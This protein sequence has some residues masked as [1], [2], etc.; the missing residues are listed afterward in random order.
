MPRFTR[1]GKMPALL[2]SP[3]IKCLTRSFVLKADRFPPQVTCPHSLKQLL[4]TK[5]RCVGPGCPRSVS[6]AAILFSQTGWCLCCPCKK[7]LQTPLKRIWNDVFVSLIYKTISR[8]LTS[9]NVKVLPIEFAEGRGW[10]DG[11]TR[12]AER[13]SHSP[14][15][16]NFSVYN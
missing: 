10:D 8:A 16:N 1:H 7:A 4:F 15:K 6:P 11:S 13:Q 14:H 12:G 2:L 3:E 5:I 9:P